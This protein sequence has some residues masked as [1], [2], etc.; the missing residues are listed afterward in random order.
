MPTID[1]EFVET[2]KIKFEFR[3]MA[4]IADGST[5]GGA[6]AYCA[7][8]QK[9]FWEYHDAIYTDV[10]NKV[11]RLGLDPKK[12]VV[13]TSTDVKQIAASAGLDSTAFATCMDAK[14]HLQDIATS[15]T[16]AQRNGVSGTPYILVN[17]QQYKGDI[18]LD[19]FRAFVKA[20]L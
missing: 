19:A 6:G 16:N 18:T 3:P 1:K 4:F 10:A 17:G 9:K 8:D 11:F 14:T 13:L 20:L 12:D 5:Q 7:V 15:T 2:G